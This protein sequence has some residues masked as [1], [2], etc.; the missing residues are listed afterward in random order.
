MIPEAAVEA[1]AAAVAALF[2]ERANARDKE[3][4]RIALEAAG[5]HLMAQALNEAAMDFELS[6]HN[7]R[8]KM[9]R[10][11]NN[12]HVASLRARAEEIREQA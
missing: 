6:P 8:A 11:F 7:S 1:A 12:A 4:A 2:G 5:P 9:A 10:H 3:T